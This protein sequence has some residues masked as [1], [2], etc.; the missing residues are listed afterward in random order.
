MAQEGK[1][2]KVGFGCFSA[3]LILRNVLVGSSDFLGLGAGCVRLGGLA[4]RISIPAGVGLHQ[5]QLR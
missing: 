2:Q 4:C 3:L 1:D 5:A